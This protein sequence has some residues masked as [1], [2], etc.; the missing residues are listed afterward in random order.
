M[1]VYKKR[2]ISNNKY[3]P[4]IIKENNKEEKIENNYT[5]IIKN[6]FTE[7]KQIKEEYNNFQRKNIKKINLF[8]PSSSEKNKQYS[9]NKNNKKSKIVNFDKNDSISDNNR[10]NNYLKKNINA[11]NDKKSKIYMK[12]I[13]KKWNMNAKSIYFPSKDINPKII[14]KNCFK[15]KFYFFGIQK[16]KLRMCFISKR[17]KIKIPINGLCVYS[18][19]KFCSSSSSSYFFFLYYV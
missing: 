15:K 9:K 17:Y 18:K 3:Q 16:Y 6:F 5:L 1:M 8:K 4:N 7:S 12:S 10:M 19:N 11:K 2:R 13:L 14:N